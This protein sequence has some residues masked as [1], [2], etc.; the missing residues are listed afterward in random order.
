MATRISSVGKIQAGDYFESCSFHP[1]VCI[2]V[3]ET[4]RNI[5]GISL[6]DGHMQNCSVIHCGI[7]KL[8]FDE[9]IKWKIV[10]PQDLQGEKLTEKWW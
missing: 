7:R 5:E 8:S 3:D 2:E 4:G 6:I 1:C 9:A 10:G